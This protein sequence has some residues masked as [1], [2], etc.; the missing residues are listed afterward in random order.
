M[1]DETIED[2]SRPVSPRNPPRTPHIR[3]D[4]SGAQIQSGTNRPCKPIGGIS[5]SR[6]GIRLWKCRSVRLRPP[7]PARPGDRRQACQSAPCQQLG[8]FRDG[9]EPVAVLFHSHIMVFIILSCARRF[10]NKKRRLWAADAQ[11]IRYPLPCGV[12][13]LH[14]CH[15]NAILAP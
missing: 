10:G 14:G 11:T 15:R 13:P 4:A 5:F 2:D 9:K 12:F 1:L 8:P 3:D 7:P 6:G